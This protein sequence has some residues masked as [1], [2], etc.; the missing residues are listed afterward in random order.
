M[1][2]TLPPGLYIVA[3]PIGNLS[4]LS[5][6]AAA[7]L[8]AADVIAVEDSRV[9]AKLLAHLGVKRPML[10][11]HDHNADH[12][13]PGLIARMAGEAVALVSDA[14][15]PLIS[16]PGYKLVRD[17]RA[18]GVNIQTAAG[19]CAAIAALTLA[20]LPTD[21]FLFLGFLP[22][23]AGARAA[24]IAEVAAVRTTLILYESG[25]RLAATLAALDE[26]LGAREAAV[27]REI[28]KKFEETVTGTLAELATRYEGA[29]PKGEIV[30]V[31]GPPGEAAPAGE[32]EIDAALREAMG[33]LSAS[34]AAAEVAA[35]LGLPRKT[36]YERALALK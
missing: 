6:H 35:A 22:P 10:P 15:T 33:R 26:G 27:V 19:P 8:S 3:T 14:G 36:V 5:P 29:P 32:A 18:A 34:R 20:G 31:V 23:K 30:I 2:Q 25:P 4:D 1:N 11:Y 16:D 9:T 24:A 21:R 12:V 7:I 13:R 28:S 17:A